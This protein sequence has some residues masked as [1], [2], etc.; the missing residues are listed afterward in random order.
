MGGF[1]SEIDLS[2]PAQSGNLAD[3]EIHSV[4]DLTLMGMP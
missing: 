1:G 2:R 4:F 3:F